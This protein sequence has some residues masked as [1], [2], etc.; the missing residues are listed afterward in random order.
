[1]QD[2]DLYPWLVKD[3]DSRLLK[4]STQYAP[5]MDYDSLYEFEGNVQG[6]PFTGMTPTEA[7]KVSPNTSTS[8][9]PLSA[10]KSSYV[11]RTR[12]VGPER[13]DFSPSSFAKVDQP[14]SS[15]EMSGFNLP[16]FSLNYQGLPE[17][18]QPE[19]PLQQQSNP[20]G[21]GFIEDALNAVGLAS[22]FGGGEE[23]AGASIFPAAN[24][25]WGN[26]S[27]YGPMTQAEAAGSLAGQGT[28][29]NS[30]FGGPAGTLGGLAG[31]GAGAYTG[32]QQAT[33]LNDFFQ[34]DRLSTPQ[35]IALALPT[36]G[37]S[38][39]SDQIQDTLGFGPSEETLDRREADQFLQGLG[40]LNDDFNLSLSDGTEVDF[41]NPGQVQNFG[42]ENVFN[43]DDEYLQG[44][45]DRGTRANYELDP[46]NP[47]SGTAAAYLN[48][49]G[50]ILAQEGDLDL[51]REKLV[52]WLANA[53]LQ[54]SQI[55]TESELL[56]EV[57]NLYSQLGLNRDSAQQMLSGYLD[58]GALDQKLYDTFSH[59]INYYGLL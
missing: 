23:V 48:P 39:F 42:T 58:S 59:D 9:N 31:L 19:V 54:N 4:G 34:G 3:D 27:V 29:V 7:I 8:Q 33:G 5:L 46:T 49:L 45:A 21:L 16:G 35:Q 56:K 51:G 22:L 24:T 38:L 6:T 17:V 25:L 18:E 14:S 52:G 41:T 13:L 57:Q 32:Y 55:D 43:L 15:I 1:M 47:L 50:A 12:E 10:F 44:L 20:Q 36:F 40:F 28:L 26:A 30:L 11:D 37:V 53:I 2:L